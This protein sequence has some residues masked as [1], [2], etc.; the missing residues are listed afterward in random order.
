MCEAEGGHL[1]TI[2][3][4]EEE[5]FVKKMCGNYSEVAIGAY[6]AD[7][8]WHWVTGESWDYTLG[9]EFSGDYLTM[10]WK[11]VDEFRYCGQSFYW[12]P[13]YYICEWDSEN[14]E[15]PE[16]PDNAQE[17]TSEESSEETTEDTS[18]E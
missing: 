3:S 5:T 13:T 6:P 2:T 17:E 4:E 7:G 14:P 16:T 11:N 8:I 12:Y 9:K 1:L 10:D 18:E 15:I